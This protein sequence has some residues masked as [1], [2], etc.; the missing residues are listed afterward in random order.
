MTTSARYPSAFILAGASAAALVSFSCG[1]GDR[2]GEQAA[3]APAPRAII[4]QPASGDTVG[5]DITVVLGAEGVEVVAADGQRVAG[6]G[7]HHLFIDVD[8]T[9]TDSAIPAGVAGIVHIGTG[10][11]QSTVSGL[12]PGQ[13]RIIAVLAY[14]NHVPMEGVGT[15]TAVVVVR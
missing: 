9:P 7:H 11:T 4:L 14:G 13:H 10:A 6:R 3:Q 8:V 2:G 5:P 15:D 12:T 1:G